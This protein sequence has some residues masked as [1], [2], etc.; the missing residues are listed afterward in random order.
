LEIVTI[1][2]GNETMLMC[3]VCAEA[4]TTNDLIIIP[5]RKVVDAARNGYVPS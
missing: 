1:C 5:P 4:M 2:E 3:D